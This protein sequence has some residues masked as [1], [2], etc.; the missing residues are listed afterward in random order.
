MSTSSAPT[1][2]APSE[3]K[4][5]RRRKGKAESGK[6]ASEEPGQS[7]VTEIAAGQTGTESSINGN[8][9]GYESP[10]I[11]ELY[12]NIRNVKKKLNA[13]QKVDSIVAENPTKSLDELLDARKINADQK[14]Q[15]QKKPALQASLAQL[16]EQIAQYKQFDVEYQKRLSAEKAAL[17]TAHGDEIE[18]VKAAATAEAQA[19]AKALTKESLLTLSKFLR[20]AAAKRQ[21]GDET[22][23]EN[24]AFEGALLLV[25]GGDASA[26]I[27]IENLVEGSDDKVPFVDGTASDFT[28]KHIRDTA[29]EH[30]P[31][32]YAA[33]E[34]WVEE[35]AQ[36]EPTVPS[37]Q[38]DTPEVVSD[39]TILHA[40]LTEIDQE[41]EP[42]VNGTTSHIDTPTVP[43][44]SNIDAGAA[45]A[46]GETNWEAKMSASAA[47]GPD[48]WVEVPR[49]PAETDTGIA[50]TP[51][52]VTG[53]QS[54]AE[55]VPVEPASTP[56]EPTGNEGFHEVHHSN[57]GR[58]RGGFHGES[59]GGF[60]GRGG[61]FRNDRGGEGGHRGR[62]GYRGDRGGGEGYRG[63]GGRRGD[64]GRGDR[65][66]ADT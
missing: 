20:A 50:A 12:K 6:N 33:E 26:V 45:N 4:S 30:A 19:K 62:G 41:T 48:G 59:R 42:K 37:T 56:A 11:K 28:Y 39:P 55:D 66:R 10:Y 51:A 65:G 23:E 16:E 32:T 36:S 58:G 54:W 22:S 31:S 17:E 5:S 18:K 21:D 53:A 35:V 40:G 29:A 27:A 61:G 2:T 64:R 24:R 57:R 49:D 7:P 44:A 3:A 25:Y 14:A 13:T 46:A 52:A 47:S 43:D 60:R 15:A 1:A 9:G 38:E 34:A 8:E 63:R